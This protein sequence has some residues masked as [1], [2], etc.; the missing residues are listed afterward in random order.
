MGLRSVIPS[1]LLLIVPAAGQSLLLRGKVVMKDGSAPSKSIIVER[2]CYGGGLTGGSVATQ[3]D[4]N[5]GFLLNI[6]ANAM[7]VQQCVLRGRDTGFDSTEVGISHLNSWSDPYLPAIVLLPRD[8]SGRASSATREAPSNVRQPWNNAV[9][10]I[11]ESN[12]AAAE[13]QLQNVVKEAPDFANGWLQLGTVLM[14]LGKNAEAKPALERALQADP[15]LTLARVSLIRTNLELKDWASLESLTGD[16]VRAE[17]DRNFPEVHAHLAVARYQLGNLAGAESSAREAIRL[18]RKGELPQAEVI[19]ATILATKADYA[20]AREHLGRYLELEPRA[21]DAAAIR[22]RMA[23]LENPQSTGS[24]AA[25]EIAALAIQTEASGGEAWVPGGMRA[26]AA[27]AHM[28]T[29]PSYRTFFAD[30]CRTLGEEVSVGTAQG[31]PRFTENLRGFLSTTSQL[32][33]LGERRGDRTV[34]KLSAAPASLDMTARVL[35]MLGWTL[36]ER[37]GAV[38]VEPGHRAEDAIPQNV[39]SAL[40]IDQ[41]G[42]EQALESGR[43]FTIE[44]FSENAR[45]AGGDMWRDIVDQKQIPDGGLAAVFASDSR[46][47]KT[48]AGLNGMDAPTAAALISK[49]GLRVL[50]QRHGEALYRYGDALV[51]D[52]GRAVAPGGDAAEPAWRRLVGSSP[53]DGA[54]FL[55]DLLDKHVGRMAAFYFTLAHADR[56]HQQY[57]TQS[58]QRA[59]RFYEW[60]RTSPELLSGIVRHIPGWPTEFL[61]LAPLNAEGNIRYPGGPAAWGMRAQDQEVRLESASLEALVSVAGLEQKHARPLTPEAVTLL[62]RNFKRWQALFPY[63]EVLPG[64]GAGE[65]AALETFSQSVARRNAEER[66][67]VL[68]EWYAL[69][70]LVVRG[71]KAGSLTDAAAAIAFRHFSEG[72]AAEAHATRA[73]DALSELTGGGDPDIAIPANFLRLDDEQRES[74]ERVLDLMHAPRLSAAASDPASVAVALDGMIYAATLNPNLLVLNEDPDLLSRHQFGASRRDGD[75]WTF[76]PASLARPSLTAGTHFSGGFAGFDQATKDLMG[77]AKAPPRRPLT[78]PPAPA[79][80][81]TGAASLSNPDDLDHPDQNLKPDFRSNGRLVAI[82]TIVTDNRGR[83]IDDLKPEQFSLLDGGVRQTIVAFEPQSTELSC[84]L[85]LDITGSMSDTLPALKKAALRLI[86]ALRPGDSVA[87]FG[88]SSNVVELMPFTTDHQAARRA[89]MGANA[90]GNTALYDALARIGHEL[91][92]RTGKKVIVVFTDGEDTASLL[93]AGTAIERAKVAGV[94]VYTIAQGQAIEKPD[95]TRQLAVI[96]NSTGGVPFLIRDPDEMD[97][98][99]EK[100]AADLTHGYLLYFQPP[101]VD[102]DKEGTWRE[103]KLVV[104]GARNPR[105][106]AREGYYP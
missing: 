39:A 22:A 90:F 33:D 38:R 25:V 96:S 19:L 94:P 24:S 104:T 2:Y 15:K 61:Q 62:V 32:L 102:E 106:R 12:W 58:P 17:E 46:I 37:D 5:G 100:V 93:T 56:A 91:T 4:R 49:I 74:F 60:F 48:C 47:A 6:Q 42:M 89:V 68:G 7:N 34:I 98:V 44:I 86:D 1:L 35:K 8:P 64:L 9:K 31:Y 29:E 78:P 80:A 79:P 45:L 28:K 14:R 81:D 82:N 3:T 43:E 41:I 95:L 26:L 77:G 63:F 83:Y 70:E 92:G 18:D 87:V 101:P 20:G 51:L 97:Q 36:T 75:A 55:G 53:R 65:F 72:L 11:G 103:L 40:G 23:A 67:T 85:L 54:A 59:E 16:V 73:L 50:A 84:V 30:Y 99:F 21:A 52:G 13:R 10:A 27:I 57:F 76:S 66:N 88:F 71:V 105:V 69:L